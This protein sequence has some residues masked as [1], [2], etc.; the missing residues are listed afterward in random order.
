MILLLSVCLCVCVCVCVCVAVVY[1][2][3]QQ[4]YDK[5]TCWLALNGDNIAKCEKETVKLQELTFLAILCKLISTH[6][7]FQVEK[8]IHS[9][10]W[11]N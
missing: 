3:I 4:M 7:G 5:W 11:P 9:A 2:N 8:A 10:L 1:I 6:L